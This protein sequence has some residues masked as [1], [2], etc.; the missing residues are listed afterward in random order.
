L[1]RDP[2]RAE[3]AVGDGSFGAFYY[4][5]CCGK[6][7]RRDDEWMAFFGGIA[8]RIVEGIAPA[9]VLDAGCAIGLLV[10]AL[11][12]RGVE[13][14]GV[15]LSGYAIEQAHESVK[16]YCRRGSIVEEFTGRYDL[17]ISIEVLEHMPA[18]EAEAAI[19]NICRHT[20]DVLFSSTPFD[21]REPTHVN[22]HPPEHW[23]ELFAR[24]DFYRDT[25]YD[26]T[27]V[28]TWAV[29]YRRRTE[30]VHR[31]VRGYERAYAEFAGAA[32]DARAYATDVQQRLEGVQRQVD[33]LQNELTNRQTLAEIERRETEQQMAAGREAQVKLALALARI[34]DMERSWFWKMRRPW[35]ILKRLAGRRGE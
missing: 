19:A 21:Y 4:A 14:F 35:V 1:S 10:E 18:P 11:R 3:P 13:A 6:P 23:A 2:A 9:R 25:E 33:A 5:N 20:D 12:S 15:D 22:V 32:R 7:Y 24:H 30:P 26:A 28:T 8:D 29:R 16:P 31:I 27:F 17:V 34:R